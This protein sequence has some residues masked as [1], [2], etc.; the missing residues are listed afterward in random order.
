[1][2]V[3]EVD[4]SYA[5]EFLNRVKAIK[6]LSASAEKSVTLM[7]AKAYQD[8]D[9]LEAHQR[10]QEAYAYRKLIKVKYDNAER[11]SGLLSRE[12][13]RRTNRDPRE[14]RVERYDT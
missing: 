4:E 8:E 1:L 2:A 6:A 13:T 7:K 10:Y 3:A 12:L 9:F 14:R 5:E 11:N